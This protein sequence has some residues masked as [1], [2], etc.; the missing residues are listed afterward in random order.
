MGSLLRFPLTAG[1]WSYGSVVLFLWLCGCAPLPVD[2]KLRRTAP[3][4]RLD[5][6]VVERGT[7]A[8]AASPTQIF[9]APKGE[10][11]KPDTKA[12][13][14]LVADCVVKAEVTWA[15]S[16]R[17][18]VDLQGGRIFRHLPMHQPG[19]VVV[20]VRLDGVEHKPD[21]QQS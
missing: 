12:E 17:L 6:I 14:V 11:I 4:G 8:T 13:P 9:I 20:Q 2:E 3:D 15:S 5:A 7:D 1:P 10:A 19:G 18:Q 16:G 21:H